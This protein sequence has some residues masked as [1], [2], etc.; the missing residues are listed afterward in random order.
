MVT[1]ENHPVEIFLIGQVESTD[2]VN[3]E[4]SLTD[5]IEMKLDEADRQ[6]AMTEERLSHETLL[7]KWDITF[8]YYRI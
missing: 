1:P 5:R 6:A 7:Y 8:Q 3:E 4:E 2:A